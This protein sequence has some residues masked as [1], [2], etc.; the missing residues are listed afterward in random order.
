[1]A[2]A[3]EEEKR[4]EAKLSLG[5]SNNVRAPSRAMNVQICGQQLHSQQSVVIKVIQFSVGYLELLP[6]MWTLSRVDGL[7]GFRAIGCRINNLW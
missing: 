2:V 3:E 1:M 7:I 4:K 6:P 5:A